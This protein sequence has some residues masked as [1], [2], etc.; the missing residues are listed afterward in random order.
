MSNSIV[1]KIFV[2]S[3]IAVVGGVVVLAAGVLLAF[4]NGSFVMSGPDVT[5]INSSPFAWSTVGLAVV[6]IL[7]M[8][9]GDIGQFVATMSTR[10]WSLLPVRLCEPPLVLRAAQ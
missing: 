5:G 1:T 10:S 3:L 6:G 9:G 2:G 8:V 4:A 7:A